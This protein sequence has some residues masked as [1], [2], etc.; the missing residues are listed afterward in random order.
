MNQLFIIIATPTAAVFLGSALVSKYQT[1]EFDLKIS[2]LAATVTAVTAASFYKLPLTF[3][4]FTSASTLGAADA[5]ANDEYSNWSSRG[6]AMV[7]NGLIWGIG[8]VGALYLCKSIHSVFKSLTVWLK[9][10]EM[11]GWTIVNGQIT[12]VYGTKSKSN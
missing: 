5:A 8:A 3:A 9:T 11:K 1:G 12:P 6:S 7:T 4:I 2:T 10:Q